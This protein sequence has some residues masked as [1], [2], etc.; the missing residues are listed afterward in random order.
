VENP[1]EARNAKAEG[2]KARDDGRVHFRISGFGFL[3]DFGFRAS[4]FMI[5]LAVAHSFLIRR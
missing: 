1:R 2:Q 4:D 5:G 3:S